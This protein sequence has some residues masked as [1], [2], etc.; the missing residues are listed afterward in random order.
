MFLTLWSSYLFLPFSQQ[1]ALDSQNLGVTNHLFTFNPDF[2]CILQLAQPTMSTQLPLSPEFSITPLMHRM[3]AIGHTLLYKLHIIWFVSK[4][5]KY[6]Y[7]TVMVLEREDSFLTE[8]QTMVA[9][10]AMSLV[11][12]LALWSSADYITQMV[13]IPGIHSACTYTYPPP[14]VCLAKPGMGGEK[15]NNQK[16]RQHINPSALNTES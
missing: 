11:L 8:S 13:S 15:P 3:P 1:D 6:V 7:F 4:L 14:P 16:S 5:H 9:T 2:H 12:L 10:A